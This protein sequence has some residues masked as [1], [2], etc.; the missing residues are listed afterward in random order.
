MP[1]NNNNSGNGKKKIV[2]D[3]STGEE[4]FVDMTDEEVASIE[5]VVT[6]EPN[7]KETLA[8]IRSGVRD[9]RNLEELKRAVLDLIDSL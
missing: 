7:P 3:V 2:V 4:T 5:T 6:P 8:E 9:S 1:N